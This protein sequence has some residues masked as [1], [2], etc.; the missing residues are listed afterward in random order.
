QYITSFLAEHGLNITATGI[1]SANDIIDREIIDQHYSSIAAA[2]VW[3]TPDKLQISAEA[4]DRFRTYFNASWDALLSDGKL[5]NSIQ[6][7]KL[8]GVPS[9]AKLN[10]IWKASSQTKVAPGVYAACFTDH[11]LYVINGFYPAMKELYT[12][13][14]S[15]VTWHIVSFLPETLPW[16]T[17]RGSVIGATNPEKAAPGSLRNELFT[18]WSSLGM[19]YPPNMT[20]N[21]IHAS[22]G[23]IEG[24]KER[25]IWTGIDL[26]QDP[27][28][29]A[30]RDAGLTND[31]I[32]AFLANPEVTIDGTSGPL[33][34]LT[35]DT[36]TDAALHMILNTE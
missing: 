25:I 9:G 12:S 35:E 23:P 1:L 18:H 4:K 16:K 36:D 26:S 28:G 3:N 32:E 19:Q 6:A 33:F 21:G 14:G 20:E 30:L 31:K 34:D 27:L 17:F 8:L 10:E 22:A 5:A 7:Q 13:P 24:L 11:D 15:S 29:Q 2:A